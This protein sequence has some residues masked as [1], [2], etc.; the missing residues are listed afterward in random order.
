MENIAVPLPG[1][2]RASRVH[3]EY[4]PCSFL[5][6]VC[7]SVSSCQEGQKSPKTSEKTNVLPKL[8]AQRQSRESEPSETLQNATLLLFIPGNV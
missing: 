7:S 6:S 8:P 4:S 1:Q 3:T 5:F 2:Q